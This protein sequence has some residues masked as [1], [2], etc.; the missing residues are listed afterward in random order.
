VDISKVEGKIYTICVQSVMKYGSEICTLMAENV[1][2]LHRAER[3]M[4]RWM[5][6]VK[7]RSRVT[8][9][10]SS[11]STDVGSVFEVLEHDG[12]R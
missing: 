5:C 11:S 6:C 2:R 8:S 7:L 4:M 9:D 10:E 1:Q 3:M 12:L